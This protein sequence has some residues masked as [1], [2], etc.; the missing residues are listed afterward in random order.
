ML[1]IFLQTRDTHFD[2][3]LLDKAG[4]ISGAWVVVKESQ[5][6]SKFIANARDNRV[7]VVAAKHNASL[8]DLRENS[9]FKLSYLLEGQL[10]FLLEDSFKIFNVHSHV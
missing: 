10:V 1:A 7:A 4:L 8:A 9:L 6:R 3:H 2:R 5:V